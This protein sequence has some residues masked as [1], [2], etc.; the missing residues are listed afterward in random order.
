VRPLR[1]IARTDLGQYQLNKIAHARNIKILNETPVKTIEKN[2]VITTNGIFNFEYLV[3]ADGTHSLVRKYLGLESRKCIGL[4]CEIPK[5]TNKANWYVNPKILQS[6]YIWV[7]PHKDC[8]NIG[9]YFNPEQLSQR[10]AKQ[11]LIDYMTDNNYVFSEKRFKGA[12]I[13]YLY[14]GCIFDNVFLAGEAA[15]LPSKSTGEGIRSALVSGMEIGRKLLNADYEMTELQRVLTV[16]KRQEIYLKLFEM[17][18][19]LQ[20]Y[21]LKVFF[22]LMKR[23]W[24]QSYIGI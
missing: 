14:K 1:T 16:K 19:P 10:K 12:P 9:I 24:F 20:G 8:T 17:F 22:H 5:V 21:F 23:G 18:P 13:N 6:G 15:G 11:I 7:F 4:Y 3:G 2:R